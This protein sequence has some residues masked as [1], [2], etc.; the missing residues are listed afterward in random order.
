MA[1]AGPHRD[2]S[3]VSGHALGTEKTPSDSFVL[4]A[5]KLGRQGA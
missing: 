3:F 4:N 2:L 1:D 5:V